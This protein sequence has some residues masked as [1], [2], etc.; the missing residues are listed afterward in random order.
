MSG[1]TCPLDGQRLKRVQPAWYRCEACGQFFKLRGKPVGPYPR[2]PQRK[3]EEKDIEE[4]Q[5]KEYL[6]SIGGD[7]L[8]QFYLKAKPSVRDAMKRAWKLRVGLE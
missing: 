6:K 2:V 1:K 5:L 7:N 3:L 8:V 4:L